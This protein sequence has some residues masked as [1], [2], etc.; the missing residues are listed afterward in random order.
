MKSLPRKDLRKKLSRST[1]VT[2]IT[3]PVSLITDMNLKRSPERLTSNQMIRYI[4]SSPDLYK[5]WK[6]MSESERRLVLKES[7]F[8]T[9][10]LKELMEDITDRRKD[11]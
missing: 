4:H 6:D 3:R 10:L 11:V 9:V 7:E 5:I 1:V 2:G 8:E